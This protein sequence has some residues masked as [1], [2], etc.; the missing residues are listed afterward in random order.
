MEKGSY[1]P[2]WYYVELPQ[3]F[4]DNSNEY[5]A[6]APYTS[7]LQWDLSGLCSSDHICMALITEALEIQ[8]DGNTFNMV[9]RLQMNTAWKTTLSLVL[10]DN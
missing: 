7:Q 8:Y 10:I 2:L 9:I 3:I 1:G 4:L 5:T 6:G